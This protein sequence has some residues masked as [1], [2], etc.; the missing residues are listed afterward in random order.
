[1]GGGGGR[2]VIEDD[3]IS[4]IFDL[5]VTEKTG[6]S[7][8]G[9]FLLRPEIYGASQDKDISSE[10]FQVKKVLDSYNLG[11]PTAWFL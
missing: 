1:M 11:I 9:I 4:R 2:Q 8:I 5:D 3:F 10:L 6:K 7:H